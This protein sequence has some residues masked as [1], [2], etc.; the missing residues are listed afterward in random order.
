MRGRKS[1]DL[2][3]HHHSKQ[4]TL[5]NASEAQSQN[6]ISE[7]PGRPNIEAAG[8]GYQASNAGMERQASNDRFWRH[9]AL[10]STCSRVSP[11]V[12]APEHVP[13]FRPSNFSGSGGDR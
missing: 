2:F 11:F 9:A 10:S 7:E 12:V 3:R 8:G 4:H 13:G 6:S 1:A 5:A